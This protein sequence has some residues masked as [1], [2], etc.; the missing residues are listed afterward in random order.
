MNA[1]DYLDKRELDNY[2]AADTAGLLVRLPV[3]LG[4]EVWQV[5]N[6]PAW[7]SGVDSAEMFLFG[8]VQTPCRIVRATK[9]TVDM[10]DKWEISVFPA[11]AEARKM[12]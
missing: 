5:C 10:I 6:N 2:R 3:P 7:N 12:L 4:S 8:E 1:M 9:F 11:E